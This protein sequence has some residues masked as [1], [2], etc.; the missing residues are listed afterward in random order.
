MINEE[1]RSDDIVFS[2]AVKIKVIGVGGGGGNVV[3][4]MIVSEVF[5]IE[6]WMVNMDV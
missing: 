1:F 2:N 5:G 6:F 4:W 3:N